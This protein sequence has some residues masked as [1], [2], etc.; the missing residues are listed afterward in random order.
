[1]RHSQALSYSNPAGGRRGGSSLI[2]SFEV[3][4]RGKV[5]HFNEEGAS[6]G[7]FLGERESLPRFE[8]RRS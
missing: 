7:D 2:L 4:E 8:G 5:I 1:V 3:F 6:S